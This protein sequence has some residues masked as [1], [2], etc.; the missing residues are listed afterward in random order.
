ME[1]P[2]YR[3]ANRLLITLHLTQCNMIGYRIISHV[4]I[5][6]TGSCHLRS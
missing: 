4:P 6:D 5:I 3:I 2:L 1:Y